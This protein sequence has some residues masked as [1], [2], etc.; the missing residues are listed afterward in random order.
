MIGC[1]QDCIWADD[2]FQRQVLVYT[3]RDD[4]VG[5]KREIVRDETASHVFLSL[6]IC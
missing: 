2:I 6:P 3:G 1:L 4:F 5:K